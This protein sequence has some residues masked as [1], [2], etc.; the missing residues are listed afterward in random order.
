MDLWVTQ[1]L[2]SKQ[3]LTSVVQSILLKSNTCRDIDSAKGMGKEIEVLRDQELKA[4]ATLSGKGS[5]EEI[6]LP[7]CSEH[8][9]PEKGPPNGSCDP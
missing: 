3:N 1:I 6:I 8:Q 9:I 4:I 7:E 5:G 2:P